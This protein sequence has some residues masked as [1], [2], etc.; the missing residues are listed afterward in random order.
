M[1]DPDPGG[2]G[3]RPGR[4]DPS[5]SGGTRDGDAVGAILVAWRNTVLAPLVEHLAAVTQDLA[6]AR[7]DVGRLRTERD[8]AVRERDRARN[9]LAADR[10]LADQFVDL[11]A[12]DAAGRQPARGDDA[13][14][15]AVADRDGR[16]DQSRPSARRHRLGTA[17]IVAAFAL[18]LGVTVVTGYLAYVEW[19]GPTATTRARPTSPA[20]NQE[21]VDVIEAL[22]REGL[23]VQVARRGV[24]SPTLGRPG[25]GAVAD[26]APLYIFVFDTVAERE[27]VTAAARADPTTVLPAQT[28]FGTPVVTGEVRVAAGSNV[29]V[30]LVGGADETAARVRRAIAGLA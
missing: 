22:E 4:A 30:A 10:A 13:G 11:L 16:R 6:R 7:E 24:R 23:E 27:A 14:P 17:L 28:P 21:F 3:D 19:Q 9:Q 2:D 8:A 18:A 12:A 26:G 20:G 1:S 5:R 25:Q 15:L 29:I